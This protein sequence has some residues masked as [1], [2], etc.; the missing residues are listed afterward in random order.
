M[1]I[2][3]RSECF[4]LT[5]FLLL[6]DL[7]SVLELTVIDLV[8]AHGLSLVEKVD[9]NE[10]WLRVWWCIAPEDARLDELQRDD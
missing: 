10:A 5:T 8:I 1:R 6:G 9:R 4:L 7:F 3:P 2:R